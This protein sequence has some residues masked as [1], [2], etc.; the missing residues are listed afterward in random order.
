MGNSDF[1][2]LTK[3]S[4]IYPENC[5]RRIT[6]VSSSILDERMLDGKLKPY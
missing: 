3:A 5:L 6:K 1:F 2:K 4:E